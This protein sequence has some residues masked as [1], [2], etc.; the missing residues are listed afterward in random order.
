MDRTLSTVFLQARDAVESLLSKY[1]FRVTKESFFYAAFGSVEVE[2]HHRTH[3]LRLS[4]DG[5]D[6]YLCLAGAVSFDQHVHPPATAWR[7]L[8]APSSISRPSPFLEPGELTDERIAELL[9]Q[10]ELFRAS[11]AAV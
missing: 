6:R 3:W 5:K 1:G 7:P 8:D 11:K 9:T 2:Y 10:I 4:W